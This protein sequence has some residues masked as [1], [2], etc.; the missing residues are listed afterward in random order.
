MYLCLFKAKTLRHVKTGKCLHTNGAWPEV[1][2]EMVLWG[3]CDER[4]LE[5][6]FMKQGNVAVYSK[7]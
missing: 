5:L 6:W 1:N 3:G 2:K 7:K 4:R